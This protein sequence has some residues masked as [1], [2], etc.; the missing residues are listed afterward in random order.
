[1]G[2]L[3]IS[4]G[5]SPISSALKKN[6][7]PSRVFLN[8]KLLSG[9]AL[10][11]VAMA[12]FS[13]APSTEI[14]D[15]GKGTNVYKVRSLPDKEIFE[16]SQLLLARLETGGRADLGNFTLRFEGVKISGRDTQITVRVDI[17]GE[18]FSYFGMS[19]NENVVVYFPNGERYHICC[20]SIKEMAGNNSSQTALA[21][22]AV[23]TPK[24]A[25]FAIFELP[26]VPSSENP[27]EEAGGFR[28]L[29]F[30]PKK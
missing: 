7:K 26:P 17:D 12:N 18:T 10:G 2:A 16:N 21:D 4:Q 23:Q 13:C 20:A 8:L 9:F 25:S 22:T 3:K 27:F 29:R 6:L 19:L 1:M 5:H 14:S 24:L 30:T 28:L 15:N 11:A